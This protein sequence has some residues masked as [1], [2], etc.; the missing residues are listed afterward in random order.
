MTT[1][2]RLWHGGAPGLRPGDLIEPRPED[3]RRHLV[4]GCPTCQAMQSHERPEHLA[5]PDRIYVTTDRVYAS[6]YAA[7]YPR[8]ALY[9]IEAIGDLEPT[10]HG[11]GWD[12]AA[13][14]WAVPAAR[15]ISVYD[16]CVVWGP[17]DVRRI[18][19]RYGALR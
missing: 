18:E 3:D 16:A 19:R 1:T 12:D 15:V 6:I 4:D 13:P 5:R 2:D 14:S 11:P 8:G 17:K 7:G 9:R 10:G